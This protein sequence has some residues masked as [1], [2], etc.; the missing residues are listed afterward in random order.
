MWHNAYYNLGFLSYDN[1]EFP[2]NND[3]YSLK[4]A[5]EVNSKIIPFTKEYEK[6]LMKEYFKFIKDYPL[7]FIKISFAKFGVILMYLIVCINIGF[8]FIYKNFYNKKIMFFFLPGIF[9][10]SLLGI[11]A[12]PDYS[13]LLGMFTFASLMSVYIVN[14]SVRKNK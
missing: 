14:D 13:Y 3:S 4:K 1:S 10:N 11:A 12:E 6:L 2:K 9:L 8:Y 5:K 7:Y